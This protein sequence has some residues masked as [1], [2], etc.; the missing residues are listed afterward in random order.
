MTEQ[1]L[2]TLLQKA[3]SFVVSKCSAH[4]PGHNG[5]AEL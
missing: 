2:K 4:F 1:K 3:E 5:A